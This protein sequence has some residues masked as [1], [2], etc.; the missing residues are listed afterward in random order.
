MVTARRELSFLT[1]VPGLLISDDARGRHH[2]VGTKPRPNGQTQMKTQPKEKHKNAL[3]RVRKYFPGVTKV[4]DA[5]QSVTIAVKKRDSIQGRKKD[6]AHCALAKACRRIPGVTG[7]IINIGSSYLI[8]GDTATRYIT[9]QTVGREI[10]SFDRHQDFAAGGDYRLSVVSKSRRLGKRPEKYG[11]GPRLTTKPDTA[12]VHNH[13][14]SKI[15]VS[16]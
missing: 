2:P 3:T 13:R 7:A 15:R 10:T 16:K 12:I 6:P 1:M 5:T 4:V 9:S 14:T 8:K 11:D